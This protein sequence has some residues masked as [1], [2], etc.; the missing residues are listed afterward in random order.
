MEN[1]IFSR[2]TQQSNYCFGGPEAEKATDLIK[3]EVLYHN[4][5]ET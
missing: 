3:A 5:T 4:Y 1:A 2:F